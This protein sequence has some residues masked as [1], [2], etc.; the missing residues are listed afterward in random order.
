MIYRGQYDIFVAVLL[1]I[2][3]EMVCLCL[4]D[5]CGFCFSN[6]SVKRWME[7]KSF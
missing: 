7:G 2:C 5:V 3:G 4:F 1:S 6:S